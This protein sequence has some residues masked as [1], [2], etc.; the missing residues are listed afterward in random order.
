MITRDKS[1]EST[2]APHHTNAAPE[3]FLDISTFS[4]STDTKKS[5]KENDVT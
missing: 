3:G 1:D 2:C 5:L 4:H